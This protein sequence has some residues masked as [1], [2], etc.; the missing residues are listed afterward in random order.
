M[1]YNFDHTPDRRQTESL[2]WNYYDPDVLPMWVADMDFP[3]PEPVLRALQER[4]AH[5][6]FGY[7][8]EMPELI[9]SV[10][11][12]LHQRYAW[13]VAPN[14]IILLPGVVAAFNLACH[15]LAEPGAAALIQTPVYP[16]FLRAPANAGLTRQEMELT[17]TADGYIIDFDA[18]EAAINP[19][20]R[21]FIL[22]NPHNP[23]GRAF[24]R[25]ELEQIAA[26]C[27][28]HRVVICS[29]EIHCD[30]VYPGRRH[31][32]IAA[33][34]AEIAQNTI[35]LMAPSKTFN[36]PGLHGALAIVPNRQLRHKLQMA[37]QGLVGSVNLLGQVATAAAYRQGQDWLDALLQYLQ[38]NR[39]FL[40]DYVRRELPGITMVKPE[41]TYLA[42]LDCRSSRAAA[43]PAKFFLEK[44]RVGLNDGAEFGRGGEGFVRLNFGCRRALLQQ[45]L[46]QM[47][48][49]LLNTMD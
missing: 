21:L 18:F 44:A 6:V 36:I 43:N 16:P 25:Q 11:R 34:G 42:W 26:I 19:H 23:V 47:K 28:R 32:P 3:S 14:E 24:T 22:C 12:W 2:K 13:D 29:D 8:I 1:Q 9:H 37:R 4:I 10:R 48:N 31:I 27:L 40:Y 49:A 20:T 17:P 35:T 33:L 15:A 7:P 5:G 39:D 38:G 30:L 46:E 45:A 41:A